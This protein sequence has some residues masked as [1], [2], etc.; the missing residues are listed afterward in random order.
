MQPEGLVL[1][2]MLSSLTLYAVWGG[3]D[4]GAGIW[5]FLTAFQATEKERLL[6]QRAI[7]PVWEA[8]HV[9]LIF[10]LVLMANGFP[11]A[12]AALS[13]ALCLPLLLALVGI[14]LRGAALA[15]RSYA[16]GTAQQREAWQI[17]FALASAAGPFFLGA[18]IG[19][20]ASGRLEVTRVGGFEGDYVT[21]WLSPLSVF[22][23]FFATG[24]CSFLAAIYLTR[25]AFQAGDAQLTALWR[26]RSLATGVCMGVLAAAGLALVAVKVP[27]LWKGFTSRGL[28]WVLVSVLAG[29]ESLWAMWRS[30][31]LLAAVSSA[32]AVAAVIWGWGVSQ[33]PLLVP[34]VVDIGLAKAP[35]SVLRTM[36]WTI[37]V[38][39]VFLAPSLIFLFVLF[40]RS[41][42]S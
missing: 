21:G 23:A 7:G 8:N 15:F 20:V 4:F 14:V 17:V 38:G 12:F 31:L 34:P 42:R 18:C 2:V 24:L 39:S 26:R 27:G 37:G 19:A 6:I 16:V 30:K 13:R 29:I 3:A 10:V 25:E 36:V 11:V 22:S 32:T 1:L 28:P 9:W 40:K 5:E 41:R 33:Y 35:D